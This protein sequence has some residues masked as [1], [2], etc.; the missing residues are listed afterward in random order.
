MGVYI[1][2]GKLDADQVQVV[3]SDK[4]EGLYSVGWRILGVVFETNSSYPQYIMGRTDAAATLVAE[5]GEAKASVAATTK[6]IAKFE[7]EAKRQDEN[8]EVLHNQVAHLKT[9]LEEARS[10]L[11]RLE[12]EVAKVRREIGEE[13]WRAILGSLEVEQALGSKPAQDD[14]PF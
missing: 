7:H 2:D 14:V 12:I 1:N 4:V 9:G 8:K 6:T 10:K 5:L 13:R 11:S 3:S